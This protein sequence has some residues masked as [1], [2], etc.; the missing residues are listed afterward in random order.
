MLNNN[1]PLI[2]SDHLRRVHKPLNDVQYSYYLTGLIQGGGIWSPYIPYKKFNGLQLILQ[3]INSGFISYLKKMLK[4][5]DI[6]LF[7]LSSES[8]YSISDPK[9]LLNI[10][11]LTKDKFEDCGLSP[12]WPNFEYQWENKDINK[13][14]YIYEGDLINLHNSLSNNLWGLSNIH[15]NTS[16][17]RSQEFTL[18]YIYWITGFIDSVVP[19]TD[20]KL[21]LKTYLH[22]YK[23]N[24]E[25][26]TNIEYSILIRVWDEEPLL[27]ISQVYGS[28]VS[29]LDPDFTPPP[30]LHAGGYNLPYYYINLI[31]NFAELSLR[32]LFWHLDQSP[33]ISSKYIQYIKMRKIYR[34]CQRKEH[35]TKK[36]LLKIL[37]IWRPY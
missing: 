29:T 11:N 26:N 7:P 4:F 33:L 36:G 16:S 21:H 37:S 18:P 12:W 31:F 24:N 10:Y 3:D 19:N 23:D 17:I 15:P 9:G 2:I 20:F 5:G 32:T 14:Y 34:I 25:L 30:A 13:D 28:S 35:L 6:R 8:T 1:L 27:L 22:D